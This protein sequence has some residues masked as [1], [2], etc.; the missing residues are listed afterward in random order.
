MTIPEK[1]C[2]SASCI[3]S[4]VF[5]VTSG[6]ASFRSRPAA[7]RKETVAS[8]RLT[9]IRDLGRNMLT[10][11]ALSLRY[12]RASVPPPRRSN[13]LRGRPDQ[14]ELLAVLAAARTGGRMAVMSG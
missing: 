10:S 11:L 12:R 13:E 14:G 8:Y 4:L 7:S 2:E 3:W 5:K 6:K 9:A 1:P